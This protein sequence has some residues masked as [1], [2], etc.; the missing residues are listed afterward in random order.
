MGRLVVVQHCPERF[1]T[2]KWNIAGKDKQR[3][4]EAGKRR[5]GALRGV[6]GA[7][8]LRL[9]RVVDVFA[10]TLAYLLGFESDDGDHTFEACKSAGIDNMD[11]QGK[12]ADQ[13][14]R[15]WRARS[16]AR[17]LACGENNG[18]GIHCAAAAD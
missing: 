6:A 8:L 9:D 10:Q 16:Q 1:G 7:L 15:F 12:A 11:C 17:G 5:L 13:V 4:F 3:T 14:E 2:E 18:G